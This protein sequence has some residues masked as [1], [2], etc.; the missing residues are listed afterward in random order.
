MNLFVKNKRTEHCKYGGKVFII[1]PASRKLDNQI[2]F[3]SGYLE[4]I[5]ALKYLFLSVEYLFLTL[6]PYFFPLPF[7]PTLPLP[8]FLFTCSLLPPYISSTHY[9]LLISFSTLPPSE[10]QAEIRR[11]L[12]Q[13]LLQTELTYV[14]GLSTAISVFIILPLPTLILSPHSCP[15]F[16]SPILSSPSSL[17]IP[18]SAPLPLSPLLSLL[19]SPFSIVSFSSKFPFKINHSEKKQRISINQ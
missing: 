19:P 12:L 7:L 5:Q 16:S 3:F 15:P 14:E 4:C 6:C 17:S 8:F 1:G 10:K 11:R 18:L 9:L 13:E 2:P